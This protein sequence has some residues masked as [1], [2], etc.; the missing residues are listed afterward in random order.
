LAASTFSWTTGEVHP[1]V[2]IGAFAL[3]AAWLGAWL[4]RGEPVERG[5]AVA[6][7][8][9]LATF[10]GALNGPLHD[11]AERY[12]FSAHMVQHLLLTLV[13]PPLLLA[14]TPAWMGDALLGR[15]R[16]ARI[17]R[18][19]TRPVPA[20]ALY[21]A[22]LAGWHFPAPYDAALAIPAWHI[23]EHGTLIVTA[24]LAW[25]PVLGPS[26][27]APR[28]HYGAQI[29]YLFVF[30]IPMTAIAALITGS[31]DL[32][33]RFYAD[34]PRV[35]ALDPLEDQRVGGLIMWIPAGIIPLLAFTAVFF[36]W[37]NAEREDADTIDGDSPT[38]TGRHAARDA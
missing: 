26:T 25:W 17:V 16:R 21:S 3:G 30:G 10:L 20:L 28:V 31:D 6:F 1:E 24:T 33:Y 36:R 22:A 4:V 38:Q 2:I 32:L 15:G 27:V 12:L 37:V 34:A 9:G 14:G 13:A 29:L 7:F 11:L 8:A 19:L 18:A 23:V 35:V 5:R